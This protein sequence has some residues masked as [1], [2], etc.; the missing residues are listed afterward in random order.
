M[1]NILLSGHIR[2]IRPPGRVWE[3][4][5]GLDN[6]PSHS[7]GFSGRKASRPQADLLVTVMHGLQ[8]APMWFSICDPA[9]MG[10]ICLGQGSYVLGNAHLPKL[11]TMCC[12]GTGL[13]RVPGGKTAQWSLSPGSVPQVFCR[14]LL[15]PIRMLSL[16]LLLLHHLRSLAPPATGTLE[17]RTGLST[18]HASGGQ[19]GVTD[20]LGECS[21][22]N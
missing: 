11:P 9:Q 21:I 7:S 15:D 10:R 13:P 1:R 3:V 17:G 19:H 14:M 8:R 20:M 16:C 18:P 12:Q 22:N 4:S 5:S 2:N 6:S